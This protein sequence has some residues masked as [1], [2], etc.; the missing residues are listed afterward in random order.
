MR[1]VMESGSKAINYQAIEKER[2]TEIQK[3]ITDRLSR[4]RDPD[5]AASLRF[6][7]L[8]LVVGG[9]YEGARAQLD[10]FIQDRPEY[11]SFQ[12]RTERLRRHCSDLINAIETKRQFSGLGGLP[13]AKQQEV[14][15]KVVEHFEELKN[16]LQSIER[17]EKEA[18]L[19]DIRSTTWVVKTFFN[20]LF[21]LI[22]VG[23]FLEI[24]NGLASS[25]LIV[26][27]SFVGNLMEQVFRWIGL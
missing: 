14:Y 6:M 3:S 21:F 10:H 5:G 11:R 9:N 27:N 23:M 25:M 26:F 12:I 7:V 16:N 19:D 15:E 18:R 4:S 17:Y 13:L 24:T 1:I 8:S 2:L 20:C 22:G